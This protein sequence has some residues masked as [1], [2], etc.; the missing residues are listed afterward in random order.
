[1]RSIA[2]ALFIIALAFALFALPGKGL[3]A[4]AADPITGFWYTENQEGGVELYS[5]G[6]KICGRFK[7]LK[8]TP[9]QGV[10]RDDHNPDI[11][12]R[13]RLLCH[14]EFMTGFVPDG[15]GHYEDGFIYSPRHGQNFNAEMTLDHDTL[16]LH[17]YVMMPILGESQTWTRVKTMPDCDSHD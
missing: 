2:S 15:H 5:C 7:W 13:P 6:A 1:M 16:D 17:G 8:P 11:A 10:A 9:D 4:A 12:K 3:C 14:M